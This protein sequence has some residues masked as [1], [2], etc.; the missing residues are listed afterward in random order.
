[1]THALCDDEGKVE[2][3]I[4]KGNTGQVMSVCV[5]ADSPVAITGG[6]DNVVIPSD[7]PEG[8]FFQEIINDTGSWYL[9]NGC[10][11]HNDSE[12]D[13]ILIGYYEFVYVIG[14]SYSWEYSQGC[15]N[16]GWSEPECNVEW[17]PAQM[18]ACAAMVYNFAHNVLDELCWLEFPDFKP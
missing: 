17:T 1:M 7:C 6:S 18:K 12:E 8:D 10:V 13:S 5:P 4:V 11:M 9:W 14:A 15:L 16:L 2:I 3:V